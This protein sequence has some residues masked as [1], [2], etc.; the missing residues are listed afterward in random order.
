MEATGIKGLDQ[1]VLIRS[2][3][4]W[5]ASAWG[6]PEIGGKGEGKAMPHLMRGLHYS[7]EKKL[8]IYPAVPFL[9]SLP[10][11]PFKFVGFSQPHVQPPLSGSRPV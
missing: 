11:N 4:E 7:P 5:D 6:T 3:S 8:L 2:R 1:G 10:L 9:S